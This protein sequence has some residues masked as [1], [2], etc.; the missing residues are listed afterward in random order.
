MTVIILVRPQMGENIGTAARVMKNFGLADLR[1]VA[2]RD[3]WPNRKAQEMSA[4]GRSVID[5]ARCYETVADAVADLSHVLATT[6]R[7]RDM[8]KP[9]A[10]VRAGMATITPH[11]GILFGPERTGL[12]NDD[13]SLA[14]SLLHIPV[15]EEYPSLNI[16]M[17]VGVV[18]YELFVSCKLQVASCNLPEAATKQDI[19]G[20]FDHLEGEL[21][22]RNFW[23]V[24]EKKPLM[25]QHIQTLLMRC[26]LSDQEVRTLR[27][28][29]RCL[30]ERG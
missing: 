18:C 28:I 21:D 12:E 6:A 30:S 4:G 10:D 25:W 7:S 26:N 16:G 3:G 14:D 17:A 11:S 9:A 29:I 15:G 23:R 5:T 8:N 13:L 24:P 2:P 1:L 27:G 19:K 20:M 22:A